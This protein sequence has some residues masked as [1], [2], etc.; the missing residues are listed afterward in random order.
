MKDII[1]SLI[2]SAKER[3]KNP[4]VGAFIM[5]WFVINW[6]P[7]WVM[8]FAQDHV[9]SKLS[10]VSDK[11]IW[12]NLWFYPVGLAL[13]Y[14]VILPYIMGVIEFLTKWIYSVRIIS[15]N[16]R[17][18]VLLGQQINNANL[19]VTLENTKAEFKDKFDLN[20]QIREQKDRLKLLEEELEKAKSFDEEQIELNNQ[21]SLKNKQIDSLKEEMTLKSEKANSKQDSYSGIYSKKEKDLAIRMLDTLQQE[22]IISE[23]INVGTLINGGGLPGGDVVSNVIKKIGELRLI[24]LMQKPGGKKRYELTADGKLLFDY[25]TK[26]ELF[27]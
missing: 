26:R 15:K 9:Y 2:E 8:L 17:Y 27:I 18:R 23:F 6:K 25:I 22:N 14:V 20:N 16:E 13:F 7:V 19:E 10:I 11:F 5:A 3:L 21:L 1:L 12:D 24:V 4:L